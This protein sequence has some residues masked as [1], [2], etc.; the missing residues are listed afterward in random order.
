MVSRFVAVCGGLTLLLANVAGAAFA[1]DQSINVSDSAHLSRELY[2]RGVQIYRCAAGAND[3]AVGVWV[4]Q[5]PEASLFSDRAL[6]T[7]VGEHFDGPSWQGIDGSEVRGQLLA[8]R[9]APQAGAIPWLLLSGH[10]T[11]NA[12]M[13]SQIAWVQR[14]DTRGGVVGAAVCD[15]PR[16]GATLKVPYTATYRFYR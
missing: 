2:A 13:F 14:I 10:P 4:F 7:L 5:A 8:S 15:K 3:N 16:F 6:T 11:Q 1:A 12:G 9:A